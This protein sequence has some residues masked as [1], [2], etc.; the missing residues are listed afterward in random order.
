MASEKRDFDNFKEFPGVL[1]QGTGIYEFPKLYHKDANGNTRIWQIFVR[2]IKPVKKYINKIDWN[3]L[4]ELQLPIKQQYFESKD[5]YIKWPKGIIA[6]V[7]TETGIENGKITRSVPTYFTKV[8]LEGR[9]NQRN[10]FQQALIFARSQYLMKKN[11]GGKLKLQQTRSVNVKHF[12]MLAKSEKDGLRYIKF[13]AD[14]QPK[15]DGLRCLTFL[16]KKNGGWK[17]VIIYSRTL[18]DYP[19][20][21]HMKKILYPYLNDLFDTESRPPQSIFLDGEL[22]KHGHALQDLQGYS[23]RSKENRIKERQKMI[24]LHSTQSNTSQSHMAQLNEVNEYHLYDCFYPLEL[25]TAW[26]SR[27]EQLNE[28]YNALSNQPDPE[29]HYSPKD[30]IKLVPTWEVKSLADAKKCFK[31]VIAQ[32]YEGLILRNKLGVYLASPDQ[33]GAMLRSPDLVK[34]KPKYTDEFEVVGFTDGKRGKDKGAIIWIAQ[35][36]SGVTFHVTPKD[37][38][39]Q[40]RYALFKDSQKHFNKKYA[41]RMLTVE[42]ESLSNTGV[43]LRAKAL[44]FRDYE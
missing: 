7:W 11:K 29:L 16:K 33:T 34:L 42:Y 22:Y 5:N 27:K 20:M 13:P 9:A 41:H 12:P 38:D 36:K 17:N 6:E 2:L 18:K 31:H 10:P 44:T 8:V 30:L 15:L 24:Q 37:M 43:P 32:G 4:D 26:I 19:D 23:R 39:Y 14:A 35:T 28:L 25:D 3:L 1:N 40:E 21:D